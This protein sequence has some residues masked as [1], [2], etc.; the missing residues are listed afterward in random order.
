M[1]MVN[2]MKKINE[3]YWNSREVDIQDFD[4]LL[5]GDVLDFIL[6]DSEKYS[7]SHAIPVFANNP[8]MHIGFKNGRLK[9][10]NR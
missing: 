1:T 4:I 9:L 7:P 6:Q 10:G 5:E 2:E 8:N 3:K